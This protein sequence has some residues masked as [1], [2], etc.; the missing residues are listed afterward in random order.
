MLRPYRFLFD[1]PGV[2]PF[3][4]GS[5]FSRVGGAMFGVGVIVAVS[6]RRDSYALAAAV[7]AVGLVVLATAGPLIGRLI[8]K[9]GQRRVA[10]PF[11]VTSFIAGLVMVACSMLGA[12]DWTLFV[13]YGVSAILPELGPMTRARWGHILGGDT[14]R[15]QTAL[16]WEQVADE[17]GYVVGPFLAVLLSTLVF[18]EAG[19]LAA[20][21]LYATGGFVVIANRRT[22]PPVVP[23]DERPHGLALR[24]AGMWPLTLALTMTGVIFGANEVAAVAVAD[25][26]GRESFSSVILALFAVGSMTAGLAYGAR[27]FRSSLTKRLLVT[28]A[29]MFVLQSPVLFTSNLWALAGIMLVAGLATAPLLITAMTLAQR[30]LPFALITEGIA[31]V[32]T[33]ILVGISLG[34]VLA[35]W[36]VEN[37][38]AHAAYGIAVLAG[39]VALVI[40]AVSQRRLGRIEREA[41]ATRAAERTAAP[42]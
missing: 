39:G 9:H 28:A 23:H 41:D 27:A 40:L 17:F 20:T 13:A 22:E 1:L 10:L 5:L 31:V 33:G 12:P 25:S 35:G 30:I 14:E 26:A 21:I 2:R 42:A 6:S 32:V 18:P 7:S 15:L 11:F 38:G 3:V 19:L 29:G 37:R 4:I 36:V 34:T 8:D 16:S 24:R